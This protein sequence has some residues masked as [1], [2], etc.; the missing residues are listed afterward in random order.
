MPVRFVRP[1]LCSASFLLTPLASALE[2][3]G[4]PGAAPFW[5]YSGKTGIGTS[6]EAY[7]DG[8]YSDQ[9]STG[10]PRSGSRTLLTDAPTRLPEPA[11]RTTTAAGT[12]ATVA[13][14]RDARRASRPP[15]RPRCRTVSRA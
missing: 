15:R 10:R 8:A 4:A 6:Y 13:P 5:S 9:A 12:A 3:P 2:A 1:L 11:A 7:R 14:A